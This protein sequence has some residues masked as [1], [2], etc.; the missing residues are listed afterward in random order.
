M[1]FGRLAVVLFVCAGAVAGGGVGEA[2]AAEW[3]VAVGGTGN[4]QQRRTVWS[5]PGCDCHRATRRHHYD[6]VRHVSEALRTARSGSATLPIRLRAQG[7]RGTTIVTF[8]GRVL[9]VTHAYIQVERLVLDGQYSAADTV[10]SREHRPA[11]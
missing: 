9:N 3:F 11:S 7:A 6:R 8:A 5:H 2:R 10:S 1:E 4:G